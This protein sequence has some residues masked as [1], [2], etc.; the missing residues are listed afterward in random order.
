QLTVAAP[1]DGNDDTVGMDSGTPNDWNEPLTAS[2]FDSL[3]GLPTGNTYNPDFSQFTFTAPDGTKYGFNGDGSVAWHSDRNGNT[4]SYSSSGIFSSTGRQI[5]F[6]RD[7][8]NRVTEIY[9][10]I[11]IN[12]SGSPVLTYAYDSNGNL[13]NVAQLVQR[14]PAV[15]ESTA[16]AYTNTDFPSNITAVTDAR[17]VVSAAYEYDS[18]G[19]LYRQ[20]DAYS[21]P[22]IYTYDIVNRRNTFT[23]RNGHTTVQTFNPGGEIASVQDAAGNVTTYGYDPQGNKTSATDAT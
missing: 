16:Y 1:N 10:P 23:D 5:T 19:R 22:A 9:D 12:N 15:Y 8:N 21:H 7:G 11:A 6:T 18:A 4:L 13:T 2:W 20:Y 3:F 17:G 14:S